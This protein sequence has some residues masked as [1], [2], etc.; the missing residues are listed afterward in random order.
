MITSTFN[1]HTGVLE[2]EFTGDVTLNEILNYI[3][4]TKNNKTYPRLLKIKTNATHA[5]FKF[6]IDDLEKIVLENRKSLEKY[7]AIIDAI[8]VENPK[9]TVIS[10]L[11]QELEKD[12]NYKFNIFSTNKGATEWLKNY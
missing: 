1:S 11:Y 10:M 7:D 3:I 12:E 9:T 4:A 8:I 6:S 5:N 2:S